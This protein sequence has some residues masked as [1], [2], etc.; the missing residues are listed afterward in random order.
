MTLYLFNELRGS[1]IANFARQYAGFPLVTADASVIAA[2][3]RLGAT[4]G[5]R[6]VVRPCR[7]RRRSAGSGRAGP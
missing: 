7:S 3:E 2:T 1:W 4:H 5:F 6:A